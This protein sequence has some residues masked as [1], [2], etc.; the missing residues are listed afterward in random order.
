MIITNK[1]TNYVTAIT[2]IRVYLSSPQL[3][4]PLLTP[5]G[6]HGRSSVRRRSPDSF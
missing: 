4:T 3:P 2:N 1:P 5:K 6:S